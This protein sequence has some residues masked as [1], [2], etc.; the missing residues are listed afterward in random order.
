MDSQKTT[1]C[2]EISLM[3]FGFGDSHKPNPETVRLVESI[4][5]KQLRMI[6]QEALKYSD[7][8]NL[9]GKELVFLMR[10]NKHKM[11]RFFQYLKNKQLKQQLQSLN[12]GVIE[13]DRDPIPKNELMKFIE[14]IDETGEF[15]DLSEVDEVKQSRMLRAD[16]ISQALDEKRYLEFCKARA[17]SFCS[18]DITARNS[19]KLRQWID[20]KKEINFSTN[21]MVV[22]SY[23]GYQTVAEITDYALLVRMEGKCG[24]DPLNHL[25]GN[26]YTSTMFNGDYRIGASGNNPDYSR[27]YSGQPPISV[28]EIKEVMRR[29]HCP[30]AGKLNFGGK[31]PDTHYLFAL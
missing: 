3:M 5:L 30:Q 12:S 31:L 2:N 17:T 26:Y 21:A 6:V 13:I 10:H 22:L 28:N 11:R 29:I 15:T 16:R 18:R 19:E 20:P 7:G 9:K 1:F 8:K 4:V 27:V 25:Y 23:L 14:Y 24:S